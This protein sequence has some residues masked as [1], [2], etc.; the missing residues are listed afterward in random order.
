MLCTRLKLPRLSGLTVRFATLPLLKW[1]GF[2]GHGSMLI[3]LISSWPQLVNEICAKWTVLSTETDKRNKDK[4]RR[5]MMLEICDGTNDDRPK[6]SIRSNACFDQYIYIDLVTGAG[7]LTL[8]VIFWPTKQTNEQLKRNW[9]YNWCQWFVV[10][11]WFECLV[12]MTTPT[13][14]LGNRNQH[15]HT[16]LLHWPYSFL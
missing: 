7:R 16:F 15:K 5:D 8:P 9:C 4:Y 1:H 10:V 13:W 11:I 3:Y 12:E 2:F 6:C 14:S